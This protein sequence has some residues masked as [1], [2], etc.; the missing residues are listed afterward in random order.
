MHSLSAETLTKARERARAAG[1]DQIQLEFLFGGD[2]DMAQ[3]RAGEPNAT[4]RRH[5]ETLEA[6]AKARFEDASC[7][8]HRV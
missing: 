1:A 8:T 5:T 7:T 2:A 4:L 3:H 6:S